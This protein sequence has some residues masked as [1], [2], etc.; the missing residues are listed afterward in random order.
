MSDKFFQQQ[1]S[2]QSHLPSPDPSS[3]PPSH[4]Q[5]QQPYKLAQSTNKRPLLSPQPSHSQ[6]ASSQRALD[7]RILFFQQQQQLPPQQHYP[8]QGN[9]LEQSGN[10]N[11]YIARSMSAIPEVESSVTASRSKP[12]TATSKSDSK[13]KFWNAPGMDM[14]VE[15]ATDPEIYE[16]LINPRPVSGQRA[17]DLYVEIAKKVNAQHG[18]K[19]DKK[20]IK[21][22]LQYAKSKY[23]AARK[24]V[25]ETGSGDKEKSDGEDEI[26]ESLKEQIEAICP[27][28]NK[29]HAIYG[30][31]IIR[32]PPPERQ[33]G[34][35]GTTLGKR[36]ASIEEALEVDNINI[37]NTI[38][39]DLEDSE[40]EDFRSERSDSVRPATS[41]DPQQVASRPEKRRKTKG[42]DPATQLKQNFDQISEMIISTTRDNSKSDLLGFELQTKQIQ[43]IERRQMEMLDKREQELDRKAK[44]LSDEKLEFKEEQRKFEVKMDKEKLEF[45]EEQREFKEQVRAFHKERDE[46]MK[47]NASIRKEL[48]VRQIK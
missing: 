5:Q 28:Y 31:C 13:Q 19:W 21:S 44:E 24:I 37:D 22:K 16:K 9:N 42:D 45:K 10:P 48:E 30:G 17:I 14:F 11:A 26:D 2:F 1:T 29:F 23:D 15:W 39:D 35:S 32:N 20:A 34:H 47:E 25:L 7:P 41:E 4:P 40:V 33:Y 18:T 36:A 46:L 12:K 38:Y 6:Y 3:S 8:R 27:P 43:E